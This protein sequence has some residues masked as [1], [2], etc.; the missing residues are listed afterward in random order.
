MTSNL[1]E[2]RLA[3]GITLVTLARQADLSTTTLGRVERGRRVAPTTIARIAIAFNDL[4][5]NGHA[6]TRKELFPDA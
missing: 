3:A 1:R 5:P 2:A 4:A 6:K